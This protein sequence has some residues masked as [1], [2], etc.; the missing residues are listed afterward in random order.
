M[1]VLAEHDGTEVPVV[2]RQDP[3]IADRSHRH[4][5]E[6]EQVDSGFDVSVGEI[7]RKPQ[8]GVGGCVESVNAL[9][10]GATERG[11]RRGVA[12]STKQQIDLSQDGPWDDHLAGAP[13]QQLGS[14][15]MASTFAA[16]QS[17]HQRTGVTDDQPASRA[18]TSSTRRDR[19]SS[20]SITPA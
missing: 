16:V 8:F 5:G 17:R 10:Q 7:Q 12:S 15:P 11:C 6:V 1:V 2:P 20:S 14:E 3:G 18:S 4:H 19:S 9:E 13:G